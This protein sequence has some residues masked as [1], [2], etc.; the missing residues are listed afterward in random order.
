MKITS[1]NVNG[2]DIIVHSL[3]LK[4]IEPGREVVLDF[5]GKVPQVSNALM[6]VEI[7][8]FD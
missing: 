5:T 2:A 7:K 4:P 8:C 3:G 6:Q 1:V